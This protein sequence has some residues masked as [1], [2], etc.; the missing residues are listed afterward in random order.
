MTSTDLPGTLPST[1]PDALPERHSAPGTVDEWVNTPWPRKFAGREPTNY[2]RHILGEETSV[3]P[4]TGFCFE[5]SSGALPRSEQT[6]MFKRNVMDLNWVKAYLLNDRDA[7]HRHPNMMASY[8][9]SHP[10]W[11][12]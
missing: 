5:T 11:W 6:K 3:C 7:D 2:E 4:E 1:L 8:K 9:Q 12:R 10:E